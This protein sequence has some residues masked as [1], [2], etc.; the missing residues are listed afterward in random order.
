M[1]HRGIDDCGSGKFIGQ[2]LT[3]QIISFPLGLH[4]LLKFGVV[5]E[6]RQLIVGLLLMVYLVGGLG[7]GSFVLGDK[8]CTH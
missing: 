4:L 8:G 1:L 5:A 7:L 6:N 2:L 3:R